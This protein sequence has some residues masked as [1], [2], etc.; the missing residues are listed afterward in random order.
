MDDGRGALA[1]EL[2]FGQFAFAAGLPNRRPVIHASLAIVA[3]AYAFGQDWSK[4]AS[5]AAGASSTA[6]I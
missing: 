2:E 5:K 6:Q 4:F 3:Q 1:L